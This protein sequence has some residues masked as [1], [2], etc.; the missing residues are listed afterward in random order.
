MA[1]GPRSFLPVVALT[2]M[3]S[4]C[5]DADPTAAGPGDLAGATDL[6]AAEAA[7]TTLAAPAWA[8]GQWWEWEVSFG[9]TTLDETFCSIVVAAD[10]SG[11]TLATEKTAWAKEEA[12]FDHPLLGA[13]SKALVM[14]GPD[15]DWSILSFPL[16]DGKTWTASIPNIAWDILPE[17]V[18]VAM[19]A[20]FVPQA[21]RA[22]LVALTGL[23]GTST[24]LEGEYDPAAGWFSSLRLFDIDPGQEELEVGYR[25]ASTGTNY[26]GP[27]FKHEAKQLVSLADQNGFSDVPTEGGTPYT[28]PP[29][30]SVSFTVAEGKTLFG[31]IVAEAAVGARAAI[32][33]DPAHQ[34]RHIEAHG[35]LNGGEAGLFLD[36]PALAGEW[37]LGTAGGGGYTGLYAEIFEITEGGGTL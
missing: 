8:I 18:D 24:L 29:Q 6:A 5:S 32:L 15:G 4:G 12:A 33:V 21:D 37:R 14:G 3:L 30:P 26:T 1:P 9:T 20:R 16:T 35:D 13:V 11:Y 27:W 31:Y 19:T 10:G 7:L 34:E 22:P 2:L 23:A 25:A 17:R 28:D 36:E